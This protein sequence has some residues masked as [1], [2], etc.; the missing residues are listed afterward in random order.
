MVEIGMPLLQLTLHRPSNVA[1]GRT[2]VDVSNWTRLE[3]HPI[4]PL[5]VSMGWPVAVWTYT[6]VHRIADQLPSMMSD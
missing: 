2:L 4:P 6:C 5:V 3:L 1:S